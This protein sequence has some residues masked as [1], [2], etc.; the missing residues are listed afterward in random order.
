MTG[1]TIK[2]S[3]KGLDEMIAYLHDLRTEGIARARR[4][5]DAALGRTLE[6]SRDL[7]HVSHDERHSGRLKASADASSEHDLTG[8]TG[9]IYYN[10][11]GAQYEYARGGTHSEFIDNL[12]A[13]SA[14]DIERAIDS[15]F[16]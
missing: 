4:E 16:D 13:L 1:I 3:T 2:I 8:W 9:S 7:A 12:S 6:F 10:D 14:P 15:I 5:L 11:R